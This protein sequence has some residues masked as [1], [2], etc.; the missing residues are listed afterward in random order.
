MMIYLPIDQI[1][2]I[3]ELRKSLV[4]IL[5]MIHH[6]NL[7]CYCL[8]LEVLNLPTAVCVMTGFELLTKLIYFIYLFLFIITGQAAQLICSGKKRL[9]LI[10]KCLL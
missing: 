8:E 1:Y 10:Y 7:G 5:H 9:Q 2:E 3:S 4:Y 6:F